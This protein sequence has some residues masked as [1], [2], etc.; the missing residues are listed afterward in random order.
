MFD[1][2]KDVSDELTE[3]R[4]AHSTSSFHREWRGGLAHGPER[5]TGE[6]GGKRL[7]RHELRCAQFLA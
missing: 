4:E 6:N 2:K 5:R 1:P 3:Q 7:V